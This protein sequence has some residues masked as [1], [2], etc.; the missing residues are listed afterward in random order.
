M[1]TDKNDVPTPPA[2]ADNDGTVDANETVLAGTI[3]DVTAHVATVTSL[4]DLKALRKAE[5][6]GK[7]RVGVIDAIDKRKAEI[8]DAAKGGKDA[9]ET[10]VVS[11]T[12]DKSR[13]AEKSRHQEIK[14]LEAS[15][16][17]DQKRLD[18]LRRERDYVEFPKMVKGRTFASREE[19]DAAGPD[20][21][22][23]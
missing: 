11:P 6:S 2:D 15:I 1:M 18:D 8:A 16:A 13:E 17:E 20:F 21:A 9:E 10:P 12:P 3:A 19:Q 5:K 22:D 4:D 7:D 14:E 23:V